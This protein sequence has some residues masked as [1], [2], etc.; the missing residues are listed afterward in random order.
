[1]EWGLMTIVGPILLLLVLGWA[2]L[3]N[4]RSAAEKRR[5]EEATKMRR[6]KRMLPSRRAIPTM[7][8]RTRRF[9]R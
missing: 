1:M 3:K 7:P 5:T 4:R 9:R 8:T 6:A 2:M